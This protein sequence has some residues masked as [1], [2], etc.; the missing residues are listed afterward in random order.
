MRNPRPWE[1]YKDLLEVYSRQPIVVFAGAG[2]TLADRTRRSEELPYGVGTWF[3]LLD[4]IVE[5]SKDETLQR[6][7]A[8]ERARTGE[9]WDLADWI[10]RQVD[11]GQPGTGGR[12]TRFQQLIINVVRGPRDKK[13]RHRNLP[14]TGTDKRPIKQLPSPFLRAS[15]TMN[16]IVAFCGRLAAVTGARFGDASYLGFRVEPNQRVRALVTPNFDPYLEAAASRKYKRD[17][18]KPVAAVPSLACDAAWYSPRAITN[19]SR[20]PRTPTRRP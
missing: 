1:G 12:P 11:G 7:Y 3:Q 16:A 5:A 20:S 14:V 18:L 15:P 9:P 19:G 6:L 2:A 17:L 10:S 13:G 8:R 4:T